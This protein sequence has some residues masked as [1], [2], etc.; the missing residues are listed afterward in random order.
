MRTPTKST[1]SLNRA[2]FIDRDGVVNE[3][4]QQGDGLRAPRRCEEVSFYPEIIRTELEAIR[5]LGFL[6]ILVTNQPDIDMALVAPRFVE[7]VNAEVCRRFP[8]DDVYM[9]PF[10]SDAHP[11]K[12]PNP[13]MFLQAAEDHALSLCESFHLGDTW[14]DVTAASRC[15]C[16]SL[17]WNRPY[18]TELIADFRISSLHEVRVILEGLGDGAG[19]VQ[20]LT[21][22]DTAHS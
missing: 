22:P 12:K 13:G 10:A 2:L 11:W 6:L 16:R 8:L 19:R 18:N 5:A 17:L 7:E 21:R 15:G 20:D 4:V 1:K 9:C 3:L 14:R